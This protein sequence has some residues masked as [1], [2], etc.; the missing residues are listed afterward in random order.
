[1]ITIF[2]SRKMTAHPVGLV[3]EDRAEVADDVDDTEDESTL[4]AEDWAQFEIA[5][6]HALQR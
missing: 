6:R 1:M 3:A 2:L 5:D 4:S